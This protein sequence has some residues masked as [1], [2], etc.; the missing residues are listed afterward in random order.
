MERHSLYRAITI[1]KSSVAGYVVQPF[2]IKEGGIA[3]VEDASSRQADSYE[4]GLHDD[5]LSDLALAA[6]PM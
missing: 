2:T 4:F 3:A 5:L 1:V 6:L